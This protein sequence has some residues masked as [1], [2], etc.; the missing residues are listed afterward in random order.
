MNRNREKKCLPVSGVVGN[1]LY[2]LSFIGDLPK[3]L[4]L[5]DWSSSVIKLFMP[6]SYWRK[7]YPRLLKNSNTDIRRMK[8]N[9]PRLAWCATLTKKIF[10]ETSL[11]FSCPAA[12]SMWL[13]C[14]Q[15]ERFLSVSS[16]YLRFVRRILLPWCSILHRL[17]RTAIKRYFYAYKSPLQNYAQQLYLHLSFLQKLQGLESLMWSRDGCTIPR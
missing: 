17:S 4:F 10:S 14:N 11:L 2:V 16:K 8:Q 9:P 6:F 12:T 7:K 15:F 5:G 3:T 1:K 13:F